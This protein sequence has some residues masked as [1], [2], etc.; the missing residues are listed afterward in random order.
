MYIIN[1]ILI[2]FK[3]VEINWV[4]VFNKF[5]SDNIIFKL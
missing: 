5:I 3:Y 4:T 1:K 2:V